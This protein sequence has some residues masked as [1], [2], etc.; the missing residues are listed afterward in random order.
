[1]NIKI[2]YLSIVLIAL[3]V[4]SCK[5]EVIEVDC[6]ANSLCTTEFVTITLEIATSEGEPVVLDNFYTFLDS[7]KKFEFELTDSMKARGLYLVI[8]DSELSELEREGSTLI[9]VGEKDGKNLVEHQMVIGHDCC[10]VQ[11]IE[12]AN[13]I[14]LEE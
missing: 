14:T 4:F 3:A 12:G 13:K 8:T 2:L 10:H 6:G 7:R 1:V 9:F 11:L 5:E